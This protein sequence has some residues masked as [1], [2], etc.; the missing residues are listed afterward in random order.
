MSYVTPRS[1]TKEASSSLFIYYSPPS[2]DRRTRINNIGT[3]Q[4]IE[5]MHHFVFAILLPLS[6]AAY[7]PS[8]HQ[9]YQCPRSKHPLCCPEPGQT[10]PT[11][12]T[13]GMHHLPSRQTSSDQSSESTCPADNTHQPSHTTL[14]WLIRRCMYAMTPIQTRGGVR[15]FAV[16]MLR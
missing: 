1:S 3:R 10:Q 12:C 14:T 9:A 11:V 8:I 7:H 15:F 5:T 2:L 13:Y 4:Y 16:E 6:Q